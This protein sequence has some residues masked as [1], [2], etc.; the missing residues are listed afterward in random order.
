MKIFVTLGFEN[1][2]FDRLIRAIDNGVRN[3]RISGDILIQTG[4]SL[5][6]VR[7]CE[8]KRFLQ[9]DE[10]MS[11]FRAADIVVGHAGV[12]TTLL[13]L[14]LGKIPVI[15]PRLA[16]YREH[17]DNHQMQFAKMLEK[18]KMVLVAYD[19]DDLLAKISGYGPLVE[20]L[21]LHRADA[22]SGSLRVY[23]E[24][25]LG[26]APAQKEIAP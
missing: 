15:F 21:R 22:P 25:L 6:P 14:S 11:C 9:F 13:C 16:K 2:S 1:F 23:L 5:Y 8:S 24:E 20:S 7:Y 18:R 12:G 17:V 19:D 10:I 3:R 26:Q 4:H